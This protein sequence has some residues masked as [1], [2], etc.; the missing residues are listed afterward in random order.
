MSALKD[1]TNF[2][3]T[4]GSILL[5][6]AGSGLLSVM[7]LDIPIPEGDK[8]MPMPILISCGAFVITGLTGGLSMYF[9]KAQRKVDEKTAGNAVAQMELIEK[10]F[11]TEDGNV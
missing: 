11:Q 6:I 3:Y 1:N 2:W 8:R 5:G 7:T 4:L 10:R 9:A